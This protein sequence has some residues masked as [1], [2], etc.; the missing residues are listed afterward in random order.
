M[1]FGVV[2]LGDWLPDPQT[3]YLVS[4]RERLRGIVELAVVAEEL[5]FDTFHIGEHHFNDWIVS[6]PT[7]V[8]AAIA[9][10]TRRIVLSTAAS[11]LPNH[12]PV[13]IAED[14]ATIDLLSDG[15]VELVGGR[16]I[17][18]SA[19]RHFGQDYADSEALMAEAVGLLR[20]LWSGSDVSWR[21]TMRPPLDGVSLRPRPMQVPHP[22]IWLSASSDGSVDRA[23]ELGCP[24]V[25]P[26]IST[27]R[28]EVAGLAARFRTGW[29]GSGLNPA[30]GK[31]A[32]HVH[33]H[34][35]QGTEAEI[36]ARWKPHQHSY[37]AWTMKVLGR[38]GD[39]GS[40][41]SDFQQPD[42][43]AVCGSPR[44][45]AGELLDRIKAMGG[46]DRLLIQVDQGGLPFDR[47]VEV[48][49]LFSE[50]VRPALVECTA[51]LEI[52]QHD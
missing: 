9:E 47:Q 37:L 33:L 44:R 26:T 21:G 8:M 34:V 25:I 43:Q 10:R 38:E 5:G 35:G 20:Q 41:R 11:L 4:E 3:G 46:T 1:E 12:D 50:E 45:V 22:P 52:C 14:Y 39:M 42:S 24:I 48:L 36:V 31:V 23:I 40:E 13:R 28:T 15:R 30:G 18:P 17:L 16:G 29:A 49:R 6:S 51:K 19:Y 2:T 32:L 7:P 27:G